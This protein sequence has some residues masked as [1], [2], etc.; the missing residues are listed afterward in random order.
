MKTIKT[1]LYKTT[2]IIKKEEIL[3]SKSDLEK[4]VQEMEIST[5]KKEKE[6]IQD[7]RGHY[8]NLERWEKITKTGYMLLEEKTISEIATNLNL[9]NST[10]E[11]YVSQII[12]QTQKLNN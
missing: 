9:V 5:S 2:T 7:E 10:I 8:S 12:Y 4:A 3:I 11:S 1:G 6:P